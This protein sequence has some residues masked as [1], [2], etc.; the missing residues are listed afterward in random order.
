[1]ETSID[2]PDISEDCALYD[3]KKERIY[4]VEYDD[5]NNREYNLSAVGARSIKKVGSAELKTQIHERYTP[6]VRINH[7]RS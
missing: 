2:R 5:L 7:T 4:T 1:M 3:K 6:L